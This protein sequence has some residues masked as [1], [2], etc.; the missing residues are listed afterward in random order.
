[1]DAPQRRKQLGE[2]GRQ[3]VEKELQWLKVGQNLLLA[4]Q[5]LLTKN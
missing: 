3:R 4:Y 1:M 2:F 5:T